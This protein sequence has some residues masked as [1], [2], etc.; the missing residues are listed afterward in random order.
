[1]P[2]PNY[3]AL[4]AV[5]LLVTLYLLCLPRPI[6]GIPFRKNASRSIL[7]DMPAMAKHSRETGQVWDWIVSQTVSLNLPIVQV[8]ARPLAK[9]WVILSDFRESQD[10]LMRRTREFDRSTHAGEI[11][12]GLL[13]DHH[14]SM[15]STAPQFKTHRK[16]IQDLMTTAFLNEV[17]APRIY[18]AFAALCDLWVHKVRLSEGHPFSAYHDVERAT[19]DAIWMAVFPLAQQDGL[20][21]RQQQLLSTIPDMNTSMCASK[22]DPVEF[23]ESPMPH[24]Q[25]SILTLTQSLEISMKSPFPRLAHW[26]LRRRSYMREARTYKENMIVRELEKAKLRFTGGLDGG[27]ETRCAMDFVLR[28]ELMSA[29]KEDRAPKHDTRMLFDE[30]FGLLV[31]GHDTTSSTTSWALK[32]LTDNPSV[33]RNLRSAM[34]AGF[35]EANA[36]QR[37]PTVLEI[38]KARIPYLDASQEEIFRRSIVQPFVARQAAVN[39]VVLG[40]R[41][42]KAKGR[43]GSWNSSDIHLF[44]PERWLRQEANEVVFDQNAGPMLSFGLGPRA[45]FA[46][47]MA[48]LEMKIALVLLVWNFEFQTVPTTLS[49]YEAVDKLTHQPV[50]CYIRLRKL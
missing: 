47:R 8:F 36:G 45:C 48:Y 41:V 28:R 46:R 7:G 49:S 19:L 10:I 14:N 43:T 21:A 39:T 12:Q 27:Q 33:Q 29:A 15:L 18:G 5:L 37:W 25:Q 38:V 35:P 17:A 24:A 16:L 20:N 40:H 11:F 6:P 42:P 30:L 32:L 1:M 3:L 9:P 34:R 31:A 2:V 26:F 44:Q 22:D 50:Q 13:P 4:G 23:P